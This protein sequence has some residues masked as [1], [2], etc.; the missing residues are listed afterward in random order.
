MGWY[1]ALFAA[2]VF[3]LDDAFDEPDEDIVID[4]FA[5]NNGTEVGVQRETVTI[6]DDDSGSPCASPTPTLTPTPPPPSP[7]PRGN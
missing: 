4:I 5:V 3:G 1:S 7:T 2:G 6:L